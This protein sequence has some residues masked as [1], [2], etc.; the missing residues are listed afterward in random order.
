MPFDRKK[1]P[2]DWEQRRE[3]ILQR[4]GQVLDKTGAILKQ[5]CCEKCGVENRAFVFRGIL[6]GK[7]VFQYADARIYN[8]PSGKFLK[9]DEYF[10]IE[11]ASGDPAQS[12]I[13]IVLTIAHLDHDETNWSV[14]DERLAAYCQ[15]C[16]L[17][18]DAP[19]K[20]RRRAKKKYLQSLF[21]I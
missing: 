4:A 19:E 3:R 21:P 18:Y 1:Y 10:P 20:R 16:H 14:K 7:E 5:A 6:H 8:Y 17:R 2:P 9:I 13:E 12:A 15:Q 11:P